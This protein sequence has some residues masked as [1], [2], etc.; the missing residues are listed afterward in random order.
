MPYVLDELLDLAFGE[1]SKKFRTN[2][3]AYNSMFAFTSIGANIDHSVNR[4]PGPYVFKINGHCHHLMGSLLPSDGETPKFAQLYIYDTTNEVANRL[5]LFPHRSSASTLY[6]SI[7]KDLIDMLNSTNCL[8]GLFRHASQRLSMSDN[9]GSKLRLLVDA[10]TNVEEDRLDYIRMNQNNLQT[11]HYQ[12]INEAVLRGDIQGSK[13]GKIIL[14]SSLTGSPRYM[15]NNYQDTMAI[16]RAYGNP[17]LFITF[18]CNTSWPEIR[19]ELKKG[20]LYKHE[21][22]PDIITRVFRAKV[23]DMLKFIKSGVPFSKTIAGN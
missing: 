12:G 19:K 14:P 16:C 6:E 3:R 9:P 22:K 1:A 2:I 8:V 4:Q 20:R 15:I 10:F 23:L 17:D 13:T 7:I 11:E 21:D 5:A 18:T